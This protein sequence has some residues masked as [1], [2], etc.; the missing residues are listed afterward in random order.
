MEVLNH[1]KRRQACI[2]FAFFSFVKCDSIIQ[3][4]NKFALLTVVTCYMIWTFQVRFSRFFLLLPKISDRK[5]LGNIR[6]IEFELTSQC[7]M[8]LVIRKKIYIWFVQSQEKKFKIAMMIFLF[9]T[10]IIDIRIRWNL[11]SVSSHFPE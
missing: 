7:S 8:Q 1:L 2:A 10:F 9:Y 6:A 3:K 11:Q 4:D 5:I